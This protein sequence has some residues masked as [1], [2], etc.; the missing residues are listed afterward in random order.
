[1]R[2]LM[3]KNAEEMRRRMEEAIAAQREGRGGMGG[4][5]GGGGGGGG[6]RMFL[7]AMFA[8]SADERLIAGNYLSD[9]V[10]VWDTAGKLRFS[11]EGHNAGAAWLG[12]PS[13]M[14][15]G[16]SP[17]ALLATVDMAGKVRFVGTKGRV[18]R[19]VDISRQRGRAGGGTFVAVPLVTCS[20]DATLLAAGDSSGTVRIWDTANGRLQKTLAPGPKAA[21][22]DIIETGPDLLCFSPDGRRLAVRRAYNAGPEF[23]DVTRGRLEKALRKIG[24]HPIAISPDWK[25]IA[26]GDA[27]GNI[28]L[29]GL[30]EESP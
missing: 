17:A 11:V 29:Y 5:G 19:Q 7:G 9:A 6:M 12:F 13:P 23:W 2:K 3:V 16:K 14:T 30:K 24:G 25:T 20:S 10:K 4:I 28:Y 27:K 18:L 26:A 22:K 1:M 21:G 8:F 15:P